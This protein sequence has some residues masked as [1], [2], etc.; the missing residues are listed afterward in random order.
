VCDGTVVVEVGEGGGAGQKS[1][2]QAGN[3]KD[4]TRRRRR[5]RRTTD[6]RL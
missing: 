4:G 5:R 2:R 6:L 1:D 3:G